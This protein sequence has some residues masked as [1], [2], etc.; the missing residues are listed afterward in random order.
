MLSFFRVNAPYQI[1]SYITVMVLLQIPFYLSPPPLLVP[2]LDWMLVGEKMGQGFMIYRDVWDN[3]SPFAAVVYWLID[4]L[5]GRSQ[6]AHRTIASLLIIYQAGYFNYVCSQ[7]QLFMERNYVP[8]IL[9]LLFANVS[10]DCSILSPVLIATTFVLLAFGTLIKQIQREGATD[11]VFEL[12]FYLSMATLFYLPFGIFSFWAIV[13]LLLYS[14]VNFRQYALGAFGFVFPI[15][16]T[17]LF[18][19]F[20]NALDD[21]LR[22][23]T[24]SVI[25]HFDY[26]VADFKNILLAFAAVFG[27]GTLGFLQTIGYARFINYQTRCQQIMIF[28]VITALLSIGFM[29]YLAPLQFLIFVPPFAFFAVNFFMLIKRRW[30][31][32]VMFLILFGFIMFRQFSTQSSQ[33]LAALT[34]KESLLP[35][36]IRQQKIVV[37]GKNEGE[38]KYNYPTTAYINWEL[39]QYDFSQLDSYESVISIYNNFTAD[40][41]TYVIDKAALMPKLFV[42]LPALAKRYRTTQW[43]GIYQRI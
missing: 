10:F 37:L 28:W 13:S 8:G 22:N 14:G 15:A 27:L 25:S 39:A 31:A 40:P 16:L 42:R 38:Y 23:L 21:L 7:R 32:E 34:V 24:T 30:I 1:L 3:I 26:S 36:Q 35:P 41:P 5:F 19:F 6:G 18:F 9:Y 11:E 33:G 20:R 2:E 29:A 17:L 4:E 43:K 12:G